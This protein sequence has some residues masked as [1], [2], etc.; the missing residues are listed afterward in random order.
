MPLH[1]DLPQEDELATSLFTGASCSPY[2]ALYFMR[3]ESFYRKFQ[4]MNSMIHASTPHCSSTW[5]ESDLTTYMRQ[6]DY[7]SDKDLASW[8]HCFQHLLM[9][10]KCRDLLLQKRQGWK[11][12]WDTKISP[13]QLLLK[14]PCHT[15]RVQLLLKLFPKAKF[16]Y[17]H[18]DPYEVFLSGAYMAST[19]YGHMFLQ[20]PSDAMLQEYILKQ[21]ELLVN[22]Y[23]RCKE[24]GLLTTKVSHSFKRIIQYNNTG[25]NPVVNIYSF[26]ES[27]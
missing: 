9:K 12:D 10:L 14:S 17:I 27:R 4:T 5:S 24:M 26:V 16:I 18:R 21:G 13:R 15:G 25:P 3:D 22:E 7:V 8:V 1:F 20:R 2:I 6:A 11:Q 19:T 23:L